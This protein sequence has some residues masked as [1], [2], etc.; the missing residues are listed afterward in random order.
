[1]M[2]EK[3]MDTIS[4]LNKKEVKYISGLQKCPAFLW[5]LKYIGYRDSGTRD[6]ITQQENSNMK[7]KTLKLCLVQFFEMFKEKVLTID[8]IDS[9]LDCIGLRLQQRRAKAEIS[10]TGKVYGFVQVGSSRKLVHVIKV[11]EYTN[12][13]FD[14]VFCRNVTNAFTGPG[15]SWTSN[16]LYLNH[17]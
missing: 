16:I 14:S 12:N 6:Y 17:N 1:M 11:D 2:Q 7:E 5:L 9:T 4:L 8:E 10:S 3:W 15:G 13:V